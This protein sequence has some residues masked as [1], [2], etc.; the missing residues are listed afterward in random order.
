LI[1]VAVAE[2]HDAV[3]DDLG[4][5]SVLKL[6]GKRRKRLDA[7]IH[8]RRNGLEQADTLRTGLDLLPLAVPLF[9]QVDDLGLQLQDPPV[10][11]V[12]VRDALM[13]AAGPFWLRRLAAWPRHVFMD[14]ARGDVGHD[15]TTDVESP[16][17]VRLC[18]A[19]HDSLF[20]L[21]DVIL[22]QSH[23]LSVSR[24]PAGG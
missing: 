17:D 11:R 12:V 6:R 23:G 10:G 1:V 16:G 18:H 9:R 19:V 2:V 8:F 21:L 7:M 22:C 4:L 14:P 15:G 24:W 20:D 13:L 3:F 5:A